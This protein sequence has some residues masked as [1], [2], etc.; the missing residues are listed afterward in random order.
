MKEAREDEKVIQYIDSC[1]KRANESS[2]SRAAKIQVPPYTHRLI[3]LNSQQ[4]IHCIAL[5]NECPLFPSL[6]SLQ[7][8]RVLPVDLSIGGGELTPTMKV[9]R[10]VVQEKHSDLITEM[11]GEG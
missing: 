7:K 11:Y 3:A 5:S 8:F 2:V 4:C 10:R 6:L 1:I 9:K